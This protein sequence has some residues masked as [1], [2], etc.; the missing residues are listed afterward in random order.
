[1]GLSLE[2]LVLDHCRVREVDFR[3]AN[4]SRAR[5][6]GSEF[7]LSLFNRTNLT[8]ADFSDATDFDIDVLHNTLK[9]ARFSRHEAVRLL[10]GLDIELVD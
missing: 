4:L 5:C 3:E 8:G 6:T 7:G 10:Y 9:G 1:M 2:E